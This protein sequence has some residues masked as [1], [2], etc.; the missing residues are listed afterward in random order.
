MNLIMT[1][2]MILTF[3][4]LFSYLTKKSEVLDNL[5]YSN[6]ELF[7]T[8]LIILHAYQQI[9]QSLLMNNCFRVNVLISLNF[10]L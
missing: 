1:I 3:K 8:K 4:K 5:E 6:A 9:G 10:V 7:N 2:T